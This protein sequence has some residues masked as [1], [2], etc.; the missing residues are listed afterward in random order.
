MLGDTAVC[1]HPTDER[2]TDLVGKHVMIPANGRIIPIVADACW[3][4]RHWALVR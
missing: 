3:R 4:I 1:V 2:Y